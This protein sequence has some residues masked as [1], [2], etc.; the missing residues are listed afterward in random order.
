MTGDGPSPKSRDGRNGGSGSRT[1]EE[2][3]VVAIARGRSKTLQRRL[4]RLFIDE[5]GRWRAE[6]V[7]GVT[8]VKDQAV[9]TEASGGGDWCEG[10]AGGC[11]E[12]FGVV[13]QDVAGCAGFVS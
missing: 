9:G 5:G 8:S 10:E 1:I 13:Y 7:T 6:E 12:V 3:W 4:C 2:E 11:F